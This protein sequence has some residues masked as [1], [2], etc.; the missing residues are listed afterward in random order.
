MATVL[1]VLKSPD[2]TLGAIQLLQSSGYDDLEVYSP[3]PNHE[4][5]HAL[6]RPPSRGSD[7]WR[8]LVSPAV[9]GF[10]AEADH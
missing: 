7:T 3:S 6:K 5:E 9:T 2:A 1:G 10:P 4:I 8:L